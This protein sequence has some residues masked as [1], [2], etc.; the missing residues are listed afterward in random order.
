MA[1]SSQTILDEETYTKAMEGIINKHFFPELEKVVFSPPKR[2]PVCECK[3]LGMMDGH[4]F[5][6]LGRREGGGWGV[7][8]HC[9]A[10]MP[11]RAA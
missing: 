9:K 11:T 1:S 6:F 2:V 3:I 8:W 4:H 10:S 5:A 7:V